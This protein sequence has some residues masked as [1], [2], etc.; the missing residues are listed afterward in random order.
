MRL[1]E[2]LKDS[3]GW[4]EDTSPDG[5]HAACQQECALVIVSRGGRAMH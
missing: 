3:C 5:P 2:H 1:E 4:V